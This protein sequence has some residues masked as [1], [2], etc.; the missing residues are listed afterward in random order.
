MDFIRYSNI[1]RRRC[2]IQDLQITGIRHRK[3]N[4]AQIFFYKVINFV[5]ILL[6]AVK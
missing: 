4:L 6:A 5:F 1:L 2:L 3:G